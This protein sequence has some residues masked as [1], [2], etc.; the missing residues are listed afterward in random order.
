MKTLKSS[1]KILLIVIL[2]LSNAAGILILTWDLYW[3]VLLLSAIVIFILRLSPKKFVL[4]EI[5]VFLPFLLIFI[6]SCYTSITAYVQK[7]PAILYL[8]YPSGPKFAIEPKLPQ[9]SLG[10]TVSAISE[11]QV[12]VN[13]HIQR[14]LVQ[15]FGNPLNAFSEKFP[16]SKQTILNHLRS[17]KPEFFTINGQDITDAAERLRHLKLKAEGFEKVEFLHYVSK[18]TS[19]R[20]KNLSAETYAVLLYKG[21]EEQLLILGHNSNPELIAYEKP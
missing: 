7:H 19:F 6:L 2:F 3:F 5:F 13:N 20:R 15:S 10:C 21:L 8:G 9:H 14:R 12:F 1:L 17:T 11:I 4:A 16:E 18:S